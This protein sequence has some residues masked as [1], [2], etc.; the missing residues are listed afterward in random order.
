MPKFQHGEHFEDIAEHRAISR[1]PMSLADDKFTVRF[2][3]FN[4][5]SIPLTDIV[6]IEKTTILLEEIKE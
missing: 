3:V 4:P 1:R 6:S 5:L 2:G